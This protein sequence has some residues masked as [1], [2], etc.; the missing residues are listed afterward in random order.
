[1]VNQP[2]SAGRAIKE[3]KAALCDM[4]LMVDDTGV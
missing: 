4:V 3:E 1:V 2:R